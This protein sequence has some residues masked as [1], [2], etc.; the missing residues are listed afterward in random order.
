M[1][2]G[3]LHRPA[4]IGMLF[5]DHFSPRGR[6]TRCSADSREMS[7][8]ADEGSCNMSRSLHSRPSGFTLVELLV[9]IGIVAL[10]ISMLMPVLGAARRAGNSVRCASN[11][12]Q[13]GLAIELYAQKNDQMLPYAGLST[14]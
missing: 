1:R 2:G 11:L 7:A 9:V 4:L 5:S 10:L 8:G 12:R 14:D 13:V 6:P 3:H